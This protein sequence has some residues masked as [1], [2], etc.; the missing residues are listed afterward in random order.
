MIV[1]F[2]SALH[3]PFDKRVFDKEA[4][5]LADAQIDVLHIAPGD[6]S[7]CTVDGVRIVTY[8]GPK[9]LIDRI[10]QLPKLYRLASSVGADAYHCN[11]VD[12]WIIGVLLHM[13]KGVPCVF[14]VHEH[15]PEDFAEFRFPPL[16]QPLVRMIVRKVMRLLLL[17]TDRIVL[18]KHSL[19]KDFRCYPSERI[20]LVQNFV[21]LQ[22]LP[23][24]KE[25]KG[26][27]GRQDTLKLIHLGLISRVRGWPQMLA[28]LAL[29][30]NRNVEML[31]VGEFTGG[32]EA[33]FWSTVTSLGLAG[34][35]RHKHWLPFHEAM[36]EVFAADAGV[37]MFQ[38]GFFSHTHALPHKL[39][40]YMAGGLAVIAPEF[41]E[42]VAHIIEEARCGLLVDTADPQSFADA[43]DTLA[44]DAAGRC[45][46]A[47]RGRAAVQRAYNWEA[48]GKK[49]VEMYQGMG[50]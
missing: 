42:E 44:V 11:E 6:G 34:Q 43:I 23:I 47:A 38:P 46:M 14:D 15:Y 16:F 18:A 21:P 9:N 39:F 17:W 49:L 1:C 36:D 13:R 50:R 35:V 4:R 48:E 8:A 20:W 12:S 40:D 24:P 30:S 7:E 27:V 31:I 22:L 25:R 33:D 19:Y 2:V 29:A 45:T 10:K 26:Q 37:I 41:A 32:E 28:G 5:S 3:T